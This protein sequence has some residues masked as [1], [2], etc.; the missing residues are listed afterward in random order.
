MTLCHCQ[1]HL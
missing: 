1:R